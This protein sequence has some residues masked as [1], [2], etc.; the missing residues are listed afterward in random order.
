MLLF[1]DLA[2]AHECS[3]DALRAGI[4]STWHLLRVAY[5]ASRAGDSTSM[6]AFFWAAVE[7][8]SSP[9]MQAELQWFA[10]QGTALAPDVVATDSGRDSFRQRFVEGRAAIEAQL[11]SGLVR[12]VILPADTIIPFY[13][14]DPPHPSELYCV[15]RAPGSSRV[16]SVGSAYELWDMPS[17]RPVSVFTY[18]IGLRDVQLE[19]SAG[20]PTTTLRIVGQIQDGTGAGWKDTTVDRHLRLPRDLPTDAYVTGLIVHPRSSTL[21]NWGLSFFLPNLQHSAAFGTSTVRSQDHGVAFSDLVLGSRHQG[22]RWRSGSTEI[23]FEPLGA[24]PRKEPL[25]LYFQ[26]KSDTARGNVELVVTL[27]TG[28]AKPAEGQP[29]L[30]FA[31]PATVPMGI[32]EFERTLD[33]SHLEKGAYLLQV[34]VRPTG[35]PEP[36]ARRDTR[37]VLN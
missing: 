17:G 31:F 6:S 35:A 22:L 13:C 8:A 10:S 11:K 4:D 19:A 15:S 5:I 14:P 29:A 36:L 9:E 32:T 7:S 2:E 37:F 33:L 21:Q 27:W 30:T 24:S 16:R 34:A 18:A 23:L 12:F 26:I 3:I 1:G 20:E 25:E 28:G